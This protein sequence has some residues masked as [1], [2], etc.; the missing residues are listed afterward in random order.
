MIISI[1]QPNFL[2]WAPFFKKI[3]ES[4]IFVLMGHCQ[5]EK[6]NFQ[7]RFHYRNKWRT[8]AVNRGMDLIVNK[9]YVDPKGD[10][11]SIKRGLPDKKKVLDNMDHL[12]NTS[13]YLTNRNII[14]YMMNILNI[15]TQI[16]F[17]YPTSLTGTARLV[18][19]CK[20]Y[21]AKTYLSGPSGANYMDL[22]LFSEANINVKYF[23]SSGNTN[24]ILDIL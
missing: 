23:S 3:S 6:N 18:E 14:I 16:V 21:G 12:I 17:D 8:I 22:N 15:K 10:W 2:P 19:L 7:N 11:E 5:F 20:K 24:H 4:D 13:L 1:H 9:Q